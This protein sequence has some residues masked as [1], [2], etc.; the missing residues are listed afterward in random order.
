MKI[1]RGAAALLTLPVLALGAMACQEDAVQVPDALAFET[2]F[3]V[4]QEAFRADTAD[5]GTPP[6]TWSVD[7]TQDQAADGNTSLEIRFDNTNTQSKVWV[8]REFEGLEPNTV[9][10]VEFFFQFGSSDWGTTNLWTLF[11]DAD[12]T[13]PDVWD[14]FADAYLQDT[15][16]G[17]TQDQGVLFDEK[18]ASL[19]AQS[20]AD[21]TLHVAIG[22]WGTFTAERSYYLDNLRIDMVEL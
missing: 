18:A 2:S 4:D 20:S 16:N 10:E 9:Y 19:L 12:P 11:A 8:E 1:R 21:G 14:D 22:V 13:S 5:L 6:V 3:E 15:G 7:R 17:A